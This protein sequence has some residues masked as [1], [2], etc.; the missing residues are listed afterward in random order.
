[1]FLSLLPPLP[2]GARPTCWA[3]W[4]RIPRDWPTGCASSRRVSGS[5]G[6]RLSCGGT[7]ISLPFCKHCS[8]CI[9]TSSTILRR[10]TTLLQWC[11]ATWSSAT[12]RGRSCWRSCTMRV[13]NIRLGMLAASAK[14]SLTSVAIMGNHNNSMTLLTSRFCR[15]QGLR[16]RG[17][18]RGEKGRRR[19]RQRRQ[20]RQ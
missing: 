12:A 19:R 5:S 18:G 13:S 17:Q 7:M 1:M 8:G 3:G 10:P 20:R 16:A 6:K 4:A 11:P 14:G 2:S 15:V 9:L